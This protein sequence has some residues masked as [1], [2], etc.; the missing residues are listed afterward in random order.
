MCKIALPK[1]SRV[2][3]DDCDGADEATLRR[4]YARAIRFKGDPCQAARTANT[5]RDLAY[6]RQRAKAD[7]APAPKAKARPRGKSLADMSRAEL[8]EL[9]ESNGLPTPPKGWNKSRLIR[10]LGKALG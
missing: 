9:M 5:Q 8:V 7:R 10:E 4:Q 6:R 2:V 3:L 1:D